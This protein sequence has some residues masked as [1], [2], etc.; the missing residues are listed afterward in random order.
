MPGADAGGS[1]TY[2][3]DPSAGGASFARLLFA[4]LKQRFTGTLAVEQRAPAGERRVWLRGGMPVFCDWHSPDDLLGE[5]LIEAGVLQR[6]QLEQALEDQEMVGGLLGELMVEQG[7]LDEMTLT[8]ALRTQCK[9]KLVHLFGAH[10][11]EGSVVVTAGEHDKGKGGLG[12]LNVL[13]LLTRGVKRHYS[14]ARVEAEIGDALGGDLVATPAFVR[15]E[16]QF[17][18]ARED[19]AILG[20]IGRGVTVKRL[21]SPRVSAEQAL[22]IIYVLWVTQMLRTGDDAL[23]AIAKGKTAAAN[24]SAAGVTL[25]QQGKFKPKSKSKPKSRPSKPKAQ[26]KPPPAPKPKPKPKAEAKPPPTPKPKAEAKP[27]PKAE[28]KPPKAAKPK[29]AAEPAAK[30]ARS[31]ADADFEAQLEQMESRVAA[32]A[33]AFV[34]F[35]LDIEANRKAVRASWAELSK[36]FHPDSLEGRGL[37][38]LHERVS[39]V[40]AA[41]SEAYGILG[42]KGEREKL[43]EA[44]KIG[45]ED[46]KAN[47]D[48]NTVVRNAFEAELVA[49]DGDKFLKAKQWAKAFELYTKAHA[50]SPKDMDIAAAYHYSGYRAGEPTRDRATVAILELT[51]IVEEQP[52]CARGFYFMALL[53]L[54]IEDIPNAKQNFQQATKLD[55]RNIDAE[56]QLR[57]LRARERSASAAKK[58]Q[59]EEAKKSSFG[60]LRD[61]FKK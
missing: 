17:G 61:L 34:L 22:P 5:L 59:K 26:T 19:A 13:E 28:A 6:A 48:A 16:A 27:P 56:R 8:S 60:G 12:Q 11:T 53:Q 21:V 36:N 57:A 33:N 51:K 18:F 58:A 46:I 14:P 41:L 39:K 3:L 15:Y 38:H 45:G 43:R 35:G 29:P 24:A 1:R 2:S 4:L 31:S 42:N 9:R 40:F 52:V 7:M 10:A 23:Q 25:G 30:H 49:R 44:L 47:E 32:E 55:P 50:L 20:A 37:S 54:S